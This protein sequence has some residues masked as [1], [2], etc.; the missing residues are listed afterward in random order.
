MHVPRPL[1]ELRRFIFVLQY[2][3]KKVFNSD[4]NNK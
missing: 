1:L 2:N 4:M 3:F